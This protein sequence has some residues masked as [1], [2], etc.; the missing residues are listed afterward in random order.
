MESGMES[1]SL[2]SGQFLFPPVLDPSPLPVLDLECL[3]VSILILSQGT[4]VATH[5]AHLPA[6]NPYSLRA[7]E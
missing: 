3:W 4:P 5:S 1:D 6:T 7:Q 2:F